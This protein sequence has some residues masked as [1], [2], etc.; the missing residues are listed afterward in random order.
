MRNLLFITTFLLASFICHGQ[1][2]PPQQ[3]DTLIIKAVEYNYSEIL[4]ENWPCK[5]ILK[6][7]THFEFGDQKF[8]IRE[9]E[10]N[11]RFVTF[12]LSNDTS[13]DSKLT[14][15]TYDERVTISYSGYTFS[16]VLSRR[17]TGKNTTGATGATGASDATNVKLQGRSVIGALPNPSYNIRESGKV[18]VSIKVDRNGTVVEAQPGAEGTNLTSAVAWDAAKRAAMKAQFNIKPDAPEFQ[19]GTITYIFKANL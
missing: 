16:C 2:K 10:K 8:A 3:T 6:S 4:E 1:L 12:H 5:Y 15:M 7:T 11:S 19:Y 17:I 14:Y 9:V 13:T 18:V